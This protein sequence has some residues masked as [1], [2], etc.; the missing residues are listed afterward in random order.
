MRDLKVLATVRWGM[1]WNV[2]GTWSS[3]PQKGHMLLLVSKSR[4]I[5]LGRVRIISGRRVVR[6]ARAWDREKK[7]CKTRCQ[8]SG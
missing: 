2:F 6:V 8:K 5:M 1:S 4:R 3:L 7:E